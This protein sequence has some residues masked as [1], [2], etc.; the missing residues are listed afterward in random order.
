[1]A[2]V[3]RCSGCLSEIIS[4]QF[5][6]CSTCGENYDLD[7]A[8]VGLKVFAL[9][10]HKDR[11]VCHA[12]RSKVR[13]T[14]NSDTPARPSIGGGLGT[15]EHLDISC[16]ELPSDDM[17]GAFVTQR[18]KTSKSASNRVNDSHLETD[19]DHIEFTDC[20]AGRELISDNLHQEI[21]FIR[22]HVVILSQRVGEL[23]SSIEVS[24]VKQD[25]S[26]NKLMEIDERLQSFERENSKYVSC[27]CACHRMS[28]LS[29]LVQKS[30]TQL[31]KTAVLPKNIEKSQPRRK[32]KK[33][34]TAVVE[35][36]KIGSSAPPMLV[37]VVTTLQKSGLAGTDNSSNMTCSVE[38]NTQY[39]P[40]LDSPE[41]LVGNPKDANVQET[42]QHSGGEWI[43]VRAKKRNS[44]LSQM[45]TAG[46]ESTFLK[47]M[48]PRKRIHL[49]NMESEAG[50][51]L[52]YLQIL[53]P[54]VK[55]SIEE[56]KARGDYKSYKI[57]VPEEFYERCVS[58]EVWPTNARVK[59][60][61]FFRSPRKHSQFERNH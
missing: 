55:C 24:H 16:I 59:P 31:T 12:C 11:W 54:G 52:R 21:K 43:E 32:A 9:M 15:R 36:S 2:S 19:N 10:E 39:L 50:D 27:S 41:M 61:T 23:I 6:T 49:W 25:L 26:N 28:E 8:N 30:P 5:L 51:I 58:P 4:K 13:K 56:L 1:M 47:A 53:C 38:S 18:R 48:E 29:G 44:R 14:D 45:C 46:P 34:K 7:C 40:Q 3:Y 60:W 20:K 37:P 17:R 33:L 57:T 35:K 42:E 22:D